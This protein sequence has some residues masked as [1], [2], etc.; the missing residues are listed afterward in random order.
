MKYANQPVCWEGIVARPPFIPCVIR[1]AEGKHIDKPI[2]YVDTVAGI[3]ISLVQLA[4]MTKQWKN[5]DE[6]G[7]VLDVTLH[8]APLSVHPK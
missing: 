4:G 7:A 8:P 6:T 1:D 2:I 5:E 3:V